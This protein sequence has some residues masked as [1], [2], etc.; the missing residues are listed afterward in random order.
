MEN[1][2]VSNLE[3]EGKYAENVE[4]RRD[5]SKVMLYAAFED[6]FLMYDESTKDM[7]MLHLKD[8]EEETRILYEDHIAMFGEGSCRIE[9]KF[10]I[11][12][13]AITGCFMAE[14]GIFGILDHIM[15]EGAEPY[16]IAVNNF[17]VHVYNDVTKNAN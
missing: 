13:E 17:Y 16:D 4:I 2:L 10:V 11:T 7:Y 6:P 9:G 3:L 8:R 14:H 5:G 15:R 12:N 1:P